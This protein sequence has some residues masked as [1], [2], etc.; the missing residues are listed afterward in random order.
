MKLSIIIP[1]FNEE[2][3]L[4]HLL[5][6]IKRQDFSDYEVIVADA[7]SEDSTKDIAQEWGCKV[8]EGGLP[9]VGRNRGAEAAR[10]E[11][12]LFLDSDVI[13][14]RDYLELCLE[15]FQKRKLGIAIT[16]IA[17]LS[18]T[19]LNKITHDLANFFMKRV[20]NIKPHG[21]GCY[22]IITTR[23]LHYEV[24]GF[25]EDLDFGED[26]DYIERI[27]AISQFKVLRSPKLLVSTR[28]LQEEGMRNVVLKYAKS[29]FYQFRGKQITAED[30]DYTFGHPGQRRIIYSVCGEGMGHAIRGRVLLNHLTKNNEVYIFA[31]DRAYDYLAAHF[32]HVYKIGGFNTVYEDN[33]VQ[34]T[35]TFIKGMKDL[36]GDLKKSLRLM[37]SVAKAIKPQI[38]IS[39]FEFY[40]NLLSKVLRVPLISLDNMHV[41]TQAE[42]DVPRKFRTDRIAAESVVRSFIQMPTFYLIT[43]YFYPPLKN[44]NK[45]KYFPPVL[46]DAIMELEPY[47]GE[48]VLVYQTSD[49]N[50][51][52]MDILKEFDD[53]FIV[54]G[55]HRDERDENLLFKSFNED[56]FFTD[57]S[58]ARAVIANGGFTLISEALYL[59]KPVLSV[60]VK[61]QFEQIL[62]ALYMERLGYG[63]FHDELEREDIENFLSKLDEYRENIHLNYFHD[64]NQSILKELDF[65]IDKYA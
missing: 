36:P 42:L 57:L 3:Y 19:F 15:E 65:L 50:E 43:S 2:N 37:Y 4:P 55:F 12:L 14:T 49:S 23:N 41:L 27:G 63:E 20:E 30:L 32:D 59:G 13:L 21:A 60:P 8:V 53:E 61:K 35:K 47:N 25:D 40:S 11:Y 7:G 10:G 6:S 62:N 46:R 22:G 56:E 38:I 28:R 1:T 39:D 24:E 45:T 5:E 51:R 48:H 54:Y 9:A 58:Q 34:N 52:L 17:P 64:Q 29:T 26:T 33:T 18:D 31:S 16:Q 44:S